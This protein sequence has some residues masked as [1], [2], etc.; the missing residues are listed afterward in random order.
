MVL[1]LPTGSR[2]RAA[3][4]FPALLLA[5]ATTACNNSG[6]GGGV[7]PPATGE[8]PLVAGIT[9]SQSSGGVGTTFQLS[10]V[11]ANDDGDPITYAWFLDGAP[12]AADPEDAAIEVQ[13]DDPGSYL[14]SVDVSVDSPDGSETTTGDAVLVVFDPAAPQGL[15][16][17]P[18]V[19]LPGDIEED[20]VLSLRDAQL[21]RQHLA[22]LQPITD[23]GAL[24]RADFD[25]SGSVD[26]LDSELLSRALLQGEAVPSALVPESGAPGVVANLFSPALLDPN[27][28]VTV[29]VGLTPPFEPERLLLGQVSFFVPLDVLTPGSFTELGGSTTVELLIDGVFAESFPFEVLDAPALAAD[30]L[31]E[32]LALASELPALR[33]TLTSEI[34]AFFASGEAA[35]FGYEAG[36]GDVLCAM[37]EQSFAILNENEAQLIEALQGMGGDEAQVIARLAYANGLSDAVAAVEVASSALPASNALSASAIQ[38]LCNIEQAATALEKG[39]EATGYLCTGIGVILLASL[40]ASSVF[41]GA[42][43]IAAPA[44]AAFKACA[45]TLAAAEVAQISLE[46]VPDL[47]NELRLDPEGSTVLMP[48]ESVSITPRVKLT[49][50]AELCSLGGGAGQGELFEE[51]LAEPITE[52]L[53]KKF[54]IKPIYELIK[55]LSKPAAKQL[56]EVI[57]DAVESVLGTTPLASWLGDLA[58]KVCEALFGQVG[59][60][61]PVEPGSVSLT[62]S[63]NVGSI[64]TSGETF[65][66]TC[67][68]ASSNPPDDPVVLM[69]SL[70]GCGGL[71][72]G[73]LEVNCGELVMVT[74]T[75]GDNGLLLDDIFEVVVDG[76]SVLTS[77]VPVT[78]ISTTIELTTG[79][80]VLQMKGL[81]A[82]DGVGTYFINVSGGF[83]TGGPSLSGIDLTA[84]TVFTWTLVVS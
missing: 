51:L 38:T 64:S 65:V 57:E 7:Q 14:V 29:R 47:G 34:D 41:P 55:K 80:H 25:H 23:P 22:G 61:V 59:G 49:G 36:E 20:G 54:P 33:G 1:A 78:S 40:G 66:Y 18:L 46:L 44:L 83:L 32:A 43:V 21:L 10:A 39:T 77:S 35:E 28:A 45:G 62:A 79:D 15:F 50:L 13:L 53:I 12:L 37:L 11:V 71:I 58:D 52:L 82:P 16:G 6:S 17:E 76:E 9:T 81:A 69:G 19:S 3:P 4:A 74:I 68:D 60:F 75:M 56:E 72:Q 2:R 73:E 84:G 5:L 27:V 67:P 48:G 70:T 42:L 26:E 63:P 30:P 31:A 24:D 8:P